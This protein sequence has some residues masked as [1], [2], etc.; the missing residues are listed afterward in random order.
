MRSHLHDKKFI[1]YL[2]SFAGLGYAEYPFP[3]SSLYLFGDGES[4]KFVFFGC[5]LNDARAVDDHFAGVKTTSILAAINY[6]DAY[7]AKKEAPLPAMDLSPFTAKQ[8][9]VYDTLLGTGFGSTTSYAEL[10]RKSGMPR[11]ARFAGSCM[12]ANIFPVFIPCHRV[13]KTDGSMGN[14]SAGLEIKR[15]LLTHEGAL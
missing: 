10:A 11:A 14:Y 8:R 12:A 13:I 4:L 2:Q 15:F 7:L 5:H 1:A 9:K 3:V 6:L